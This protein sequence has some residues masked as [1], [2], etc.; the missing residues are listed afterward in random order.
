[1]RVI[2]AGGSGLIGRKLTSSMVNAGDE[3][4]IL[5]RNPE[6]VLGLP[7]GARAIRWDGRSIESW[8]EEIERAD[9]IV[10]LTGENL[11][12]VGILP[13]RWT[14]ARKLRLEQSRVN[15]GIV[16][17]KAIEQASHKPSVFIQVSGVGYYGT[18]QE[19]PLT[20]ADDAGDDFSANLC[21]AWE[22]SSQP[23]ESLGL[24]RVVTRNGVV[25]SAEGGVLRP[26]LLPYKL[27]I[28]GP[29]GGGRQVHSWIHIADEV[30]A[31]LFLIRNNNARGVYNLTSPQPVTNDEFGR[32]IAKVLDRPHYLPLPAFVMNLAFGEVASML[33]KGQRVLPHKL[34][35]AGFRF[36]FPRLED[37][38]VNLLL[39]SEK[40]KSI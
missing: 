32:A 40:V 2:I 3:V 34:E 31:I 24:R 5:S 20:E 18:K 19:K 7:P 1:M 37:A 39:N 26:M 22:A 30:G 4:I 33:L 27:L 28:G 23:V 25:L 15:S 9:A 8:V 35:D 10:N 21:K 36:I 16:L 6:K 38:L 11:S 29:I 17:T 13:A 12:G 14:K